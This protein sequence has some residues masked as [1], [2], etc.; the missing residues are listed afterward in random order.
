MSP[1][2]RRT[3]TTT[4]L[5]VLGSFALTVASSVK[6]R[7]LQRTLLFV[8]LGVG[9]PVLGEYYGI[10]KRRIIRHHLQP[11]VKGI[12]VA[13]A[14]GWYLIGYN[15]FAMVERLA[16]QLGVPVAYRRGFLPVMTALTAT[17]LDLL[18][19]VA[20]LDQGYWEW[21][22]DGAYASEVVGPN[23]KHGI[24]VMNYTAWLVLTS[25]VTLLYLLLSNEQDADDHGGAPGSVTAGR[26]AALLLL[27][28]YLSA[29]Q[30]ELRQ[31]RFTYI[32]YA[33]LFPVVLGLSLWGGPQQ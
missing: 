20:M 31:K 21:S 14:C 27:P 5:G 17:N 8:A 4:T 25:S 6:T 2:D 33:A 1:I 32:L 26:Q 9:L 18:T 29:L 15:T 16:Q 28:A 12:P 23:G 11:Q 10:N 30:W 3:S 7:G 22:T 24:P 19:D 13:I